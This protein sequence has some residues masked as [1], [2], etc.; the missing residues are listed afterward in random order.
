MKN[1]LLVIALFAIFLTCPATSAQGLPGYDDRHSVMNQLFD[2]AM[3][4][5]GAKWRVSAVLR[6]CGQKGIAAAIRSED[7]S[8]VIT[9]E[10]ATIV[11][12]EDDKYI[13]LR[14]LG[15]VEI[16]YMANTVFYLSQTYEMGY[17]EAVDS[18]KGTNSESYGINCEAA[19]VVANQILEE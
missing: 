15:P 9:K 11:Y 6:S 14:E 8:D 13:A 19:V 3:E 5:Y 4:K 10:L 12:S 18:F 16:T 2:F 17:K 1:T 7:E